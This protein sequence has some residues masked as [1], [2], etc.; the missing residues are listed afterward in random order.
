MSKRTKTAKTKLLSVLIALETC[1]VPVAMPLCISALSPTPAYAQ[2]SEELSKERPLTPEERQDKALEDIASFIDSASVKVQDLGEKVYSFLSDKCLELNIECQL[3]KRLVY[4]LGDK[5]VEEYLLKNNYAPRISA[6]VKGFTNEKRSAIVEVTYKLGIDKAKIVRQY[7]VGLVHDVV[8]G[9]IDVGKTKAF[10]YGKEIM[11]PELYSIINLRKRIQDRW[12]SFKCKTEKETNFTVRY[13]FTPNAFQSFGSF[14][15]EDFSAS[16]DGIIIPND[17]GRAQVGICYWLI[18]K[19]GNAQNNIT[20]FVV[21]QYINPCRQGN[22]RFDSI[23]SKTEWK[24]GVVIGTEESKFDRESF[25]QSIKK[26]AKGV[27]KK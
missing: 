5:D 2:I 10:R 15:G 16:I 25:F 17:M 3:E 20:T 9:I 23:I 7:E 18:D 14:L 21:E 4:N 27:L 19:Y 26:K 11:L 1:A 24:P 22:W 12:D 6:D 13:E 8:Y